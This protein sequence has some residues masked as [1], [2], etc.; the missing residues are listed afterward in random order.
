MKLSK[1]VVYIIYVV[2]A[3]LII[4]TMIVAFMPALR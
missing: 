1:R 4:V 3:I 2:I